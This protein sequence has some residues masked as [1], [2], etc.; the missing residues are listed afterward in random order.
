MEIRPDQKSSIATR[1]KA[2]RRKSLLSQSRLAF[3]LG[4][5]RQSVNEIENRRVL[6]RYET[7]VSFC[8]LE[9]RHNQARAV[10]HAMRTAVPVWIVN[11]K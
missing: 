10:T 8:A 3:A 7:W 6:A 2:L 5:C 1:F 9:A 11:S 4:V